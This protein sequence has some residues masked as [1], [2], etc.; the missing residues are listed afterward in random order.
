[1]IR[2]L[3]A[4]DTALLA[5]AADLDES[6]RLLPALRAARLEGVT[7]LVPAARTILVR[8]DPTA[9]DAAALT[10]RLLAVRP[11]ASRPTSSDA[12]TI[13]VRYDGED[14]VE[15]AAL[16]GLTA[17]ELVERHQAATWTVAFTGFAPGFGYLVGDGRRGTSKSGSS[18]TR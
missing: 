11:A 12:V 4:A 1:M 3:P 2:V 14:L 17:A 16:L 10:A 9:V 15:V 7:E 18:P 5:E 13:P 8:F 6:M